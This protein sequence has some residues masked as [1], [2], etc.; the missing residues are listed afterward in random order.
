MP[1]GDGDDLEAR[2][3][4][5]QTRVLTRT[6]NGVVWLLGIGL[7]LMAIPSVRQVGASLMASAGLI[8]LVAGFAARPVLGN[9]IAGLQ[10]GRRPL[11]GVKLL[12]QL[13]HRNL[14]GL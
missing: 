4:Q 14:Q 9:L 2:R 11:M 3:V 7:A 8:G 13:N 1:V 10:I 12:E 6:L 5:T